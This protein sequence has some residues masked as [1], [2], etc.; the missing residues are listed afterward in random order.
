MPLKFQWGKNSNPISNEK[1][2]KLEIVYNQY[3]YS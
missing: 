2:A 3:N 1:A